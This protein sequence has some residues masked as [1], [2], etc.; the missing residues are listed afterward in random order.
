[1]MMKRRNFVRIAGVPLA[2]AILCGHLCAQSDAGM[3][4][5][6]NGSDHGLQGY[7]FVGIGL[8][9][10]RRE[11]VS[12][13]HY[14]AGGE[15]LFSRGLGIGGEVGYLALFDD[16]WSGMLVLSANGSY[17]FARNRSF[18]PFLIGGYSFCYRYGTLNAMQYGVGFNYWYRETS[19]VR[20]ELRHMVSLGDART[21]F[22][23]ARIAYAFR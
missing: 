5:N 8:Q 20:L 6:Q 21:N 19:A 15:Y 1:M 16:W 11:F 14:G 9:S 17:H 10:P 2:V 23:T 22:V 7:L 3:T 13:E 4:Q 18:S 12:I